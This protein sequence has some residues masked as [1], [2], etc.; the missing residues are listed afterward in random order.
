M[1]KRSFF[2]RSSSPGSGGST[3]K[4][5]KNNA[6]RQRRKKEREARLLAQEEEEVRT[7]KVRRI[8]IDMSTVVTV[9]DAETLSEVM[10]KI[11]DIADQRRYS[12]PSIRSPKTFDLKL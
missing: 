8:E 12:F 11:K 9:I 10:K 7:G 6:D 5:K 2:C 4:K 1:D 3:A